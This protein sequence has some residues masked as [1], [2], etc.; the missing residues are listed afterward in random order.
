MA[1]HYRIGVDIGGTFTDFTLVDDASGEIRVDKC[2]TTP[3]QPEVAVFEGLG[4]LGGEGGEAIRDASAIIHA[5]TLLTNVVLERKGALTGLITTHG[6]RDV[7]EFARELRYDVFDP[8]IV[9]PK[10]LVERPLR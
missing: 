8:F 3:D 4:R 9:F 6:F 10:P 2:L 1:N 7:L 5:T